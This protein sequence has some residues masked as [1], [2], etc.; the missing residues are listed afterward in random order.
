MIKISFF[1][2]HE[3]VEDKMLSFLITC[4]VSFDEIPVSVSLT[5]NRCENA[6]NKLKVIDNQPSNETKK[7]SFG[8]CTSSLTIEDKAS[9]SRFIEWME[10][11]RILG[12]SKISS[13]NKKIEHG[14]KVIEFFQNK[15]FLDLNSWQDPSV[16]RLAPKNSILETMQLTDCFYRSKNL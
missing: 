1:T 2:A 11:L 14:L 9:V 12:A 16:L 5:G 8:V 4:P 15:N 6:S 3:K 7:K 10:M 13:F